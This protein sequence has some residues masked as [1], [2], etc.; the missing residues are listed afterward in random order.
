MNAYMEAQNND[1]K[2]PLYF[3]ADMNDFDAVNMLLLNGALLDTA[4]IFQHPNTH[5]EKQLNEISKIFDILKGKC[6]ENIIAVLNKRSSKEV[7]TIVNACDE[8][9]HT[10]LHYAGLWNYIDIILY[11]IENGSVVNNVAKCEC[12]AEEFDNK[13]HK[14]LF[15]NISKLYDDLL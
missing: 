8:H 10:L 13:A 3:A 14:K 12:A 2:T 7:L 9:G 4:N 15:K 6:P 5:S 11:L 1:H